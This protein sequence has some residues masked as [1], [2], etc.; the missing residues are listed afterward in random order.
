VGIMGPNGHFLGTSKTQLA[1]LSG[2]LS[3]AIVYC[4]CPI[5]PLEFNLQFGLKPSK[6]G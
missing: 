1:C 3:N 5:R 6:R 4:P 2:N